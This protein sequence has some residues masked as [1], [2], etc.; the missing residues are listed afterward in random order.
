MDQARRPTRR[1]SKAAWRVAQC[2]SLCDTAVPGSRAPVIA[3]SLL[4]L[5]HELIGLGEDI[6]LAASAP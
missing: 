4:L 5:R 2:C 1:V 3:G 6:T